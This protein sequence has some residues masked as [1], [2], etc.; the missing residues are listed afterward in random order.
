MSLTW[1]NVENA[2]KKLMEFNKAKSY[3][4]FYNLKEKNLVKINDEFYIIEDV[5][6]H[7]GW[8]EY[9]LRNILTDEIAYLEFDEGELSLWK[10]LNKLEEKELL[11]KIDKG[12]CYLVESGRTDKYMYKDYSCDDRFFSLE[13]YPDGSKEVYEFIPVQ[14]KKI[15]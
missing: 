5:D 10:K 1:E 8:V 3:I 14:D 9:T 7:S 6:K 2:I 15:I 4:D 11:M 13:I 12:D